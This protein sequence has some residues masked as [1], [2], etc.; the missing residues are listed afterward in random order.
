MTPD[1]KQKLIEKLIVETKKLAE[2]VD[3]A[4]LEKKGALIKAGAWYRVPD[5]RI[6]PE[7][8]TTKVRK[9]SIDSKGQLKIKLYKSTQFDKLAR[10]FAKLAE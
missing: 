1:E 3:F 8:V 7:H 5:P 9:F 6:L 10:K 4:D 2:P